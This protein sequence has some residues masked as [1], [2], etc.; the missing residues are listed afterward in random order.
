MSRDIA[1]V[2]TFLRSRAGGARLAAEPE[3]ADCDPSAARAFVDCRPTIAPGNNTI[4]VML[5][6]T[7][8]HYLLFSDSPD[9]PSQFRALV[10][11][12]G[13]ISE[14]PIVTSNEEAWER[15]REVAD[16]FVFHNRDIY[17]RADDS[18][19]RV[20]EAAR[21]RAA[22]VARLRSAS[23]RSRNRVAGDSRLRRRVEEHVLPDERPVR[24]PQPAH[25]RSGELRDAGVLRRD[26]GQP[27]EA[28][29]G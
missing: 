1:A 19:V 5:P 13:N 21:A 11:T 23:G 28:V 27:E 22:P 17:M 12:S 4:G 15:L 7:P 3:A 25:R 29:S 16:W 20:F 6:Y 10:M 8:L 14:E 9:E 24:H 26:A 18:V 2:E